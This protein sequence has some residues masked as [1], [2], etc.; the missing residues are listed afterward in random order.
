MV[1][2]WVCGWVLLF[3]RMI[4]L[5]IQ[6]S[7]FRYKKDNKKR[8]E[9][10]FVCVDQKFFKYHLFLMQIPSCTSK[11]ILLRFSTTVCLGNMKNLVLQRGSEPAFLPRDFMK[12]EMKARFSI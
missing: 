1:L 3:L 4:T 2:M 5:C 11:I 10:F 7:V 9:D 8:R 12:V 6:V